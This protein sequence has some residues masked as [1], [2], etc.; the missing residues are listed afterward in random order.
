MIKA[1]HRR[2]IHFAVFLLALIPGGIVS[3]LYPRAIPWLV[4]MSWVS[5]WYAP[6][7]AFSG[8]T[9]VEEENGD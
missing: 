3:L 2:R 8:E 6:L 1:R 7:T 9:P 4:F 5:F